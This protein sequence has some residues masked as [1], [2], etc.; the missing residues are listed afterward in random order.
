M[1]KRK[2]LIIVLIVALIFAVGFRDANNSNRQKVGSIRIASLG[3]VKPLPSHAE[4]RACNNC[5]GVADF[6]GL[7]LNRLQGLRQPGTR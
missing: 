6:A 4:G 7:R 1:M 3:I 5:H 2:Y